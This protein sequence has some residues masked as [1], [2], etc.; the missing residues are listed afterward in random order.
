MK[1]LVLLSMVI[2]FS[3]MLQAQTVD[4]VDNIILKI[5]AAWEVSRQATYTQLT[6]HNKT[7]NSFCQVAIYQQQPAA[8]DKYASFQ[9]EWNE[10]MLAYFETS[11]VPAP[12][13]RKLRNSTELYYGA[14]VRNKANQL[15]YYS[16]LHVVDCGNTIQSILVTSGSKKHL[17]VFDSLWQPLITVVRKNAATTANAVTQPPAITTKSPVNGKWGKSASSPFGLDAATIATNA[18]YAKCQYD[19]K[20][21]GTYTLRGEGWG[22]YSRS[23][24]YTLINENGTYKV[25]NQQLVIT[26]A[27]S[28]LRVVDRDGKVKK[29]NNLDISKRTYTWQMHYFE[30]INE[31]QLILTPVKE[32][33]QDGGVS[34]S[35][36]FP[37]A[38]LY[39]QDY[40]PEWRFN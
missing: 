10:L 19:F 20:P 22:G 7:N 35:G 23:N 39:S 25:N 38:Y 33:F 40:K 1:T 14:Q 4:S 9:K 37:G 31:T 36:A 15:P 24:E 17:Q 26:P 3:S 34:Q 12:Q 21:D 18:G 11:A 5:P 2:S 6:L 29:S 16:E 13:A 28:A 30:G 32:Y 27:K 8:G